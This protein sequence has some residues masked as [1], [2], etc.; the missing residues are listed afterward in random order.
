MQGPKTRNKKFENTLAK[1]INLKETKTLG[2]GKHAQFTNKKYNILFIQWLGEDINELV[3]G[4]I[5]FLNLYFLHVFPD[6]MM[7]DIYMF[8]LG[9][10]HTIWGDKSCTCVVTANEC[11]GKFKSIIKKLILNLE[12]LGTTFTSLSTYSPIADNHHMYYFYLGNNM[13]GLNQKIQLV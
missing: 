4:N 10:L 2:H 1:Y 8:G 7:F 12:N 5:H 9:L 11:L 3:S 6:E 13:Y